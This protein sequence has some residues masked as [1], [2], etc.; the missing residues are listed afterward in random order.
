MTTKLQLIIIII[1]IIII[2]EC[3]VIYYQVLWNNIPQLAEE[4]MVDR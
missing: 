3:L 2:I 4:I 1:I